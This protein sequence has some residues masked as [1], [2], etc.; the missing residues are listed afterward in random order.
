MIAKTT[1]IFQD[2]RAVGLI[3]SSPSPRTRQRIGRGVRNFDSGAGNWEKQNAVL[4]GTYAKFTQN[5]AIKKSPFELWQQ[6][7]D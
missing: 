1:R 7:S 6:A 3:I 4:S 5:L 2:D